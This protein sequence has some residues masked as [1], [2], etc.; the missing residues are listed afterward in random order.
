MY[1]QGGAQVPVSTQQN[2][3]NATTT[4]YRRNCGVPLAFFEPPSTG[5]SF[6]L[7]HFFSCLLACSFAF[8]F[9]RVNNLLCLNIAAACALCQSILHSIHMYTYFKFDRLYVI[10]FCSVAMAV[11]PVAYP[12]TSTTAAQY[13]PSHNIYQGQILYT[14]DQ[15]NPATASNNQVPQY[16]NYPVGYTYPYNGT[17]TRCNLS[18]LFLISC[19]AGEST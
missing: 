15:Y 11:V 9:N 17:Y 1:D 5:K 18:F 14:S 12:A 19:D 7:L 4:D 13:A 6:F 3:Q 16:I 8:V 10:F 2:E